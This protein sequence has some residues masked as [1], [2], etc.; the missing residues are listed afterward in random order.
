VALLPGL[1]LPIVLAVAWALLIGYGFY[2]W[3]WWA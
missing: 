2:R 3:L 1:A